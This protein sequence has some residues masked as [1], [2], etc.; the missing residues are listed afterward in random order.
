VVLVSDS[1]LIAV[2]T[3]FGEAREDIGSEPFAHEDWWSEWTQARME[4]AP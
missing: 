2:I 3:V 4:A 1:D